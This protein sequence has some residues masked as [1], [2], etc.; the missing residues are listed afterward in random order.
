[1]AQEWGSSLSQFDLAKE[2]ANKSYF[3]TWD[4]ASR[5]VFPK[6]HIRKSHLKRMWLLTNREFAVPGQSEHNMSL[7]FASANFTNPCST[8]SH[9]FLGQVET[10]QKLSQRTSLQII[11]SSL[12]GYF[13]MAEPWIQL[14]SPWQPLGHHVLGLVEPLEAMV[15]TCASPPTRGQA[16][17]SSYGHTFW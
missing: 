14:C 2:N 8:G 17:P 9:F 12:S 1:M 10:L 4:P 5:S 7:R 6:K 16:W 11:T 13:Q 15:R 3:V